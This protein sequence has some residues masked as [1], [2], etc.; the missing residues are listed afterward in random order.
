MVE[1]DQQAFIT[2]TQRILRRHIDDIPLNVAGFNLCTYFGKSAVVV[3]NVEFLSGHCLVRLNAGFHLAGSIG[4]APGDE[5]NLV[6]ECT[7]ST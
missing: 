6:G 5:R 4:A 1:F 2:P 7:A 3:D